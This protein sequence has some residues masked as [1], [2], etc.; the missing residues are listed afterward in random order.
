MNRWISLTAAVIIAV[1]LAM[2][3][4]RRPECFGIRTKPPKPKCR[5]KSPSKRPRSVCPLRVELLFLFRQEKNQVGF[6]DD[7]EAARVL[8]ENSGS[9]MIHIVGDLLE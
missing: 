4:L 7:V 3:F 6:C 1:A 2:G 8:H 5:L 9:L